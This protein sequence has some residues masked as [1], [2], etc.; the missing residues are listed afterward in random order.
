[1][2]KAC[3]QQGNFQ[4]PMYFQ[5]W[6]NCVSAVDEPMLIVVHTWKWLMN[7]SKSCCPEISPNFRKVS[8]Q[9]DS[10]SWRKWRTEILESMT[11]IGGSSACSLNT[12][13]RLKTTC[14]QL[15]KE[16]KARRQWES[17]GTIFHE[18]CNRL[19]QLLVN[20]DRELTLP[21][22]FFQTALQNI[23]WFGITQWQMSCLWKA[24]GKNVM[25]LQIAALSHFQGVIN[26]VHDL[27]LHECTICS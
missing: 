9:C 18:M 10:W 27:S 16:Q 13:H 25:L 4:T 8:C 22:A 3:V 24:Q 21:P 11:L 5:F 20:Y 2:H 17:C 19:L 1:M 26:T 14:L 7:K 12:I 23:S 15:V 6:S